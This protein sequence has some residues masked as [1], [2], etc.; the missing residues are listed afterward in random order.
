MRRLLLSLGV[1]AIAIAFVAPARATIEEQRARLPPAADCSDEIVAGTWKSHRY[2]PDFGDWE[3]FTLTIRRVPGQ[4]D[5]L[6]G[7][8]SNHS[9]G[10]GPRN[11]EPPPCAQQNMHEWIVSMDARG[12]VSGGNRIFF[13]GVGQ[14]RLDRIVC[15]SGPGGYNLDNFSGVIEPERLEFQSVNNDGGRAN[16][17]PYVFR[18][19]RCPPIE[20]AESPTVNPVPPDFYPDTDRGGCAR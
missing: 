11:E 9:W 19:I 1:L 14:W 6:T 20:S 5:A 15:R 16:N 13:G 12:N 17:T 3:I 4:P 2:N 10:G 8:I 7:T 18:R